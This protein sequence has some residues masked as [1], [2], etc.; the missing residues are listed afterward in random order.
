MS[1]DVC[2]G[3][4][5]NTVACCTVLGTN[6]YPAKDPPAGL[7]AA[8]S[9][10]PA[11]ASSDPA[12]ANASPAAA[13]LASSMSL[14]RSSDL[15]EIRVKPDLTHGLATYTRNAER[16]ANSLSSTGPSDGVVTFAR[17]IAISDVQ[18]LTELGLQFDYLEA[19]SVELEEE[20]SRWTVF[21][22][23]GLNPEGLLGDEFDRLDVEMLGIISATVR[24]PDLAVL[25]AVRDD[26][27]VFLVDLS[28]E[29]AQRL[30]PTE[31]DI[32]M[33]DVYWQMAGW[34]P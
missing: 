9:S 25:R 18:R 10:D 33:N 20:P 3:D 4:K 16:L 15:G 2:C 24:V 29:Q 32:V 22:P 26:P 5:W 12:G 8:A 11:A 17:P 23:A 14:V 34:M 1:A 19:I 6:N 21:V 30:H 13:A 31:S 7:V 27:A 28:L